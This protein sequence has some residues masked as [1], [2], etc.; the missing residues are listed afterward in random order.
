MPK[1]D[2]HCIAC[3]TVF[4]LTCK[5]AEKDDVHI[6]PH[7]GS[8]NG[9]WYISAPSCVSMEGSR[10]MTHRKDN[11][12]SEVISKIAERNPRTSICERT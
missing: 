1:Y 8:D 12:F 10:F 2:R 11:G 4:D 6:C 5:I 7:C 9:E 3:D